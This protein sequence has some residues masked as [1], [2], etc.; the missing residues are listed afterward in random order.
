M[1]NLEEAF[2]RMFRNI[3]RISEENQA[4]TKNLPDYNFNLGKLK[5]TADNLQ[6]GTHNQKFDTKS[7]IKYK[8]QLRNN[9]IALGV[10]NARKLT[11]YA[12]LTGNQKLLI[13]TNIKTIGFKNLIDDSLTDCAR[14][15]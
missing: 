13:E 10:E 12:K 15:I 7:V 1:A 14:I 2:E 8:H 6:V 3:I 11:N 4:I 9:L 5:T